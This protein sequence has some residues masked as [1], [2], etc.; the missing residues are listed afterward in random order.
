MH[1]MCDVAMLFVGNFK[2]V[3]IVPNAGSRLKRSDMDFVKVSVSLHADRPALLALS[4]VVE[5]AE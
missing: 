1:S 5:R 2:D 4:M 3:A